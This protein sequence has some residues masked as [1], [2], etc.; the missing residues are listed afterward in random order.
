MKTEAV[1]IVFGK[2]L[3]LKDTIG[4]RSGQPVQ[5]ISGEARSDAARGEK[6]TEELADREV[7]RLV[8]GK[9]VAVDAM[10]QFP[11]RRGKRQHGYLHHVVPLCVVIQ[12]AQRFR[13]DEVFC[14]MRQYDLKTGLMVQLK[15]QHALENPIEVVGFG[16]RAVMRTQ[17][18]MDVGEAGG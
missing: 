16:G 7:L 15:Q 10:Q 2:A 3:R 12:P 5:R 13:M 18:D 4:M 8:F 17:R 6:S 9:L 11:H 14:V 1:L